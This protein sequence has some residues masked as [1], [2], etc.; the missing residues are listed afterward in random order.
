MSENDDLKIKLDLF[1]KDMKELTKISPKQFEIASVAHMIAETPPRKWNA[2]QQVVNATLLKKSADQKLRKVKAQ[3][4][5]IA[6][7]MDDLKAAPDR[8]AW[9]DVQP[10]VEAAEIE[11]INADAERM[12]AKT[13]YD[14]LDDIFSAGKR[15]MQYLI[16][17][18]KSTGEYNKFANEGKR[19]R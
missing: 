8:T 11:V 5:M 4:M 12:A 18:E 1:S 2:A 17:Q 7:N 14:C 15:I 6:R 19:T 9:V 13:A 16:E 10:E 3:K